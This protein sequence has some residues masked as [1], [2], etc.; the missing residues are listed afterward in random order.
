LESEPG[1]V[2]LNKFKP[3]LDSL[4][5][6]ARAGIRY[7]ADMESD[8]D[9]YM[10]FSSALREVVTPDSNLLIVTHRNVM[11]V[12]LDYA[13]IV[14]LRQGSIKNCGYV[15]LEL[16]EKTWQFKLVDARGVQMP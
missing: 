9:A 16:D 2:Q 6:V 12:F 14:P 7:V 4:P 5:K 3:L 8:L 10:R 1:Q 13:E 11:R 15:K